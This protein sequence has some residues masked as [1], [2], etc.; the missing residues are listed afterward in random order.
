MYVKGLKF[1]QDPDYCKL[2]NIFTTNTKVSLLFFEWQLLSKG[3]DYDKD[4]NK[5]I[6]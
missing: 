2:R 5:R 1:N 3:K 4:K 6:F